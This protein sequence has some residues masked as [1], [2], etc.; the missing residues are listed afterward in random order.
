MK[1]QLRLFFR[2]LKDHPGLFWACF[3]PILIWVAAIRGAAES[4]DGRMGPVILTAAIIFSILPW[5]SVL[6]T[7]WQGRHQYRDEEV[8][9]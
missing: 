6:T 7:A 3:F 4:S 9:T 5:I 2:S 8:D 1:Y